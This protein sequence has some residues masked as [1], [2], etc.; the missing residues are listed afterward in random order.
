MIAI[1]VLAVFAPGASARPLPVV[2]DD[3]PCICPPDN[4][5]PAPDAVAD[6]MGRVGWQLCKV[7]G[8]H[9]W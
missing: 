6:P 9:P 1:V 4:C 2:G 8:G 3:D 5:G 7:L